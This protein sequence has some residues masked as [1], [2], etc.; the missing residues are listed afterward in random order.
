M[1]HDI[2]VGDELRAESDRL[3]AEEKSRINSGVV[4]GMMRADDN[5]DLDNAV[6]FS[7]SMDVMMESPKDWRSVSKR[8]SMPVMFKDSE[9]SDELGEDTVEMGGVVDAIK[10]VPRQ[11]HPEKSAW[12]KDDKYGPY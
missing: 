2:G 8:S 9:V 12:A 4:E 6:M 3:Y 7:D 1:N 5:S 10:H 11:W